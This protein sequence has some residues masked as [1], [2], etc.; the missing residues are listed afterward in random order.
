[1]ES[2]LRAHIIPKLGSLPLTGLNAKSVQCFVAYL[3]IGGRSSKTVEN[4]LLT[5]SSILRTARSWGY[6]CGD[7]SLAG[8]TMPREGVKRKQ[9]C[10]TDEEVGRIIAAASEP[11][12]TILM[13]TAVLGLR[14]GEA[15]ALRIDQP[16]FLYQGM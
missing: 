16:E 11:F 14:I 12:S 10:F 6:A 5:L 15:L 3:A 13:V 7:F 1:M 8:I 9:R 2:N 4:V